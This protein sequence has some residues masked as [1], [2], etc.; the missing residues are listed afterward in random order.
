MKLTAIFEP[1]PEGGFTC[2]IEEMPEV[3][4]E[5]DTMDE[6][7]ENLRDALSLML[8][9]RREEA[10]AGMAPQAVEEEFAVA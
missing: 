6:A 2:S 10:R 1:A 7:R 9:Y 3:I 4:S 5:G 8:E